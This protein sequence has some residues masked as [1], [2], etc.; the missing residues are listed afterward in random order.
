MKR[1]FLMF[2]ATIMFLVAGVIFTLLAWLT[3]NEGETP[4]KTQIIS[5]I[6]TWS[7]PVG[8]CLILTIV[9]KI[10]EIKHPKNDSDD[11]N[12]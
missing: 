7:I 11:E 8:I 3:Y 4:L 6:I 1:S 5:R 12:N 9:F 2:L 10:L